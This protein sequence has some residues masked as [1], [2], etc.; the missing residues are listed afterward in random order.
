MPQAYS[1]Q[2]PVCQGFFLSTHSRPG[3]ITT[4]PHCAHNAPLQDFL[5]NGAAA[6]GS[7]PIMPLRRREFRRPSD[8]HP[9]PG[10]PTQEPRQSPAVSPP[11]LVVP[12]VEPQT[13]DVPTVP[14][15]DPLPSPDPAA[16]PANGARPLSPSRPTPAVQPLFSAPEEEPLWQKAE[17]R[18]SGALWLA[19]T[20]LLLFALAGGL[21]WRE[22][23][24][25]KR[26]ENAIATANAGAVV[27]QHQ[28]PAP[29]PAFEGAGLASIPSAVAAADLSIQFEDAEL[30]SEVPSVVER[31]FSGPAEDRQRCIIP[32]E[33]DLDS[34]SAFFSKHGVLDAVVEPLPVKAV[35]LA[36]GQSVPVFRI[37]TRLNPGGG[38]A[39]FERA[40]DGRLQLDWR[41]FEETHDLRL[42]AALKSTEAGPAW[43]TVGIRKNHGLDFDETFRATHHCFELQGA[44]RQSTVLKAAAPRERPVGRLLQEKTDWRIIYLARF[45][46]QPR[47][48]ED[49][50]TYMEIL[51]AEQETL[52]AGD[53]SK[54][55]ESMPEIQI[56]RPAQ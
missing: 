21:V 32:T 31:L 40:E 1:V 47:R 16:H 2:C 33:S 49:G 34:M 3:S 20:T 9:T 14:V 17:P 24:L 56:R 52:R 51:D 44:P 13:Q 53:N 15:I 12:L 26:Q 18:R 46:L 22:F 11:S 37:G 54:S 36:T 30:L 43:F 23:A 35:L 27:E 8:I 41:L 39:R 19:L 42:E 6:L 45:L 4:C 28:E 25:T 10:S 29:A 55:Q 7:A 48:S 50:T 5:S 38:L